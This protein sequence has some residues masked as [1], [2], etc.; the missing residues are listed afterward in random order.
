MATVSWREGLGEVGAGG[1]E[2]ANE[3]FLELFEALGVFFGKFVAFFVVVEDVV[4]L[5]VAFLAVDFDDFHSVLRD[6]GGRGHA[7]ELIVDDEVV[8]FFLLRFA[9]EGGE[10]GDAVFASGGLAATKVGESGHEVV[11]G[12]EKVVFASGGDFT[13]PADYHGA[14]HSSLIATA[15]E[16]GAAAGTIKD[17]A[18][19]GGAPFVVGE[20]GFGAIGKNLI[21]VFDFRSVV[22]FVSVIGGEEDDGVVVDALFFQFGH[23]ESDMVVEHLDHGGIFFLGEGEVGVDRRSRDAVRG[24][25]RGREGV[26]WGGKERR[27]HP[28]SHG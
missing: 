28:Y 7:T 24:W 14:L 20:V 10:V 17:V 21:L 11:V 27:A 22:E 18:V 2:F 26:G 9:E 25:R 15:F 8:V 6:E 5:E 1:V 23:D 12:G 16:S 13:G 3:D 4:E 19:L